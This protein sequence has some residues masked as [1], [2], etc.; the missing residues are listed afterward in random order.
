MKIEWEP[1]EQEHDGNLYRAKVPGG[2]LYKQ[3]DPQAIVLNGQVDVD[4]YSF[5][6]SLAFVPSV[7]HEV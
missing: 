3:V 6:S 5:T 2:W 7:R 1:V 4:W